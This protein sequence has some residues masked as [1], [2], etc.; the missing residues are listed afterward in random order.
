VNNLKDYCQ[1]IK[2]ETFNDLTEAANCNAIKFDDKDGFVKSLTANYA[3][4][5]RV[6]YFDIIGQGVILIEL[7]NIKEKILYLLEN[8]TD[9]Q[10]IQN[11]VLSNLDC[12]FKDS[13]KIIKDEVNANIVSVNNYLVVTNNTEINMLDKY[14]PE[15]LKKKPFVICKTSDICKK[16]SK[17]GAKLC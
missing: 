4:N 7:K 6:D 5:C 16:L 8:K 1:L 2:H 15:H 13:L 11:K 3:N 14:L 17:L 12:K 10:E 9:K